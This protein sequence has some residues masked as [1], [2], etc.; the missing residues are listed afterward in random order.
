MKRTNQIILVDDE[1]TFIELIK[2]IIKTTNPACRLKIVL[3]GSELLTYLEI[4]SRPNL[5]LLDIQMPG[6]SGFDVLKILKAVDR[7]KS[8]PVVMLSV[9]EQKQDIVKSYDLGANGY[10]VKPGQYTDLSLTMN[11]LNQYWFDIASTPD[12]SWPMPDDTY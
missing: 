5:I 4:S 8:I 1:P 12:S 11:L 6:L 9:S 10:I 2:E 3:S 7:Y